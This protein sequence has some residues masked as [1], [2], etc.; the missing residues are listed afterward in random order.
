MKLIWWILTNTGNFKGTKA[1]YCAKCMNTTFEDIQEQER[2]E[3]EFYAKYRCKKCGGKV[4]CTEHWDF[5]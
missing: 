2:T 3:T 4:T 1:L 5:N